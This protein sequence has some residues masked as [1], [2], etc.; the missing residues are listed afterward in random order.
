MHYGGR[1]EG[2]GRAGGAKGLGELFPRGGGPPPPPPPM[3][4]YGFE[5]ERC[6][7]FRVGKARPFDKKREIFGN[8]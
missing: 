2:G 7:L 8:F 1:R 3:P 4:T 6:F 5:Y